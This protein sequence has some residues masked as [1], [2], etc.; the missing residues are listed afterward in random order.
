MGQ[1]PSAS[2]GW[3]TRHPD[4]TRLDFVVHHLWRGLLLYVGTRALIGQAHVILEVTHRT[5]APTRGPTDSEP[6]P[7]ELARRACPPW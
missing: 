2:P 3:S 5:E 1:I 4:A 6:E 7:P